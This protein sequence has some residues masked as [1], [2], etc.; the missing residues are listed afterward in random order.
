MDLLLRRVVPLFPPVGPRI[1][2]SS[3]IPRRHNLLSMQGKWAIQAHPCR[4]LC[5]PEA[6]RNYAFLVHAARLCP[7]KIRTSEIPQQGSSPLSR[8]QLSSQQ[9]ARPSQSLSQ[10][11]YG[12]EGSRA[13]LRGWIPSL[14]RPTSVSLP[15][16]RT[17]GSQ[18][19]E[20]KRETPIRFPR[21]NSPTF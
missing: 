19:R 3:D 12:A 20:K 18:K 9:Q 15:L 2:T 1:S 6:L 7:L 5:R 8:L 17:S 11:L 4:T 14:E 21:H 16:S 10:A 13:Y